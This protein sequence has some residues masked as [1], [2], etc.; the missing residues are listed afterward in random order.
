MCENL[1]HLLTQQKDIYLMHN[2]CWFL[3]YEKIK[4]VTLKYMR[5]RRYVC[6]GQKGQL[7][8][9]G[10]V[11]PPGGFQRTNSGCQAWW[12]VNLSTEWG[13]IKTNK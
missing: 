4:I 11:F 12:Q 1:F 8:G 10:F 7:S 6:R 5:E 2:C 13:Q 3:G 9:F